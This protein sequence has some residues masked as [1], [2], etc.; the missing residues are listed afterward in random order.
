M[1]DLYKWSAARSGGDITIVHSTGKVTGIT[2][3]DVEHGEVVAHGTVGRLY[4]L[5]VS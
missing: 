1:F 3:I 2:R 4:R 5:H